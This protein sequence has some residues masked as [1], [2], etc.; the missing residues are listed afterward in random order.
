M[1]P[2]LSVRARIMLV[3]RPAKALMEVTTTE[4]GRVGEAEWNTIECSFKR[5]D[6]QVGAFRTHSSR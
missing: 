3:A 2:L 1:H 4:I 5:Y 6:E